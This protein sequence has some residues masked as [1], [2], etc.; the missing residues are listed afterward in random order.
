MNASP[1]GSSDS[2]EAEFVAEEPAIE[3]HGWRSTVRKTLAWFKYDD[4]GVKAPKMG[5]EQ[6]AVD[7]VVA[8]VLRVTLAIVILVGSIVFAV[9]SYRIYEVIEGWRF[10]PRDEIPALL[11]WGIAP[12]AWIAAAGLSITLAVS[13]DD[14][15][16]RQLNWSVFAL[17]ASGTLIPSGPWYGPT[18]V[19]IGLF[20]AHLSLHLWLAS[21][22]RQ[23]QWE[24]EMD[25]LE[26]EQL[27]EPDDI[28]PRPKLTELYRGLAGFE[29]EE[30]GGSSR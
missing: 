13:D 22:D 27:K 12:L 15:K 30:T 9:K 5:R 17:L 21:R 18:S 2:S 8:A 28:P 3:V 19:V 14:R 6:A 16:W 23:K 7:G 20:G 26:R 11:R 29:E 24:S 10:L 1:S 4:S 25:R